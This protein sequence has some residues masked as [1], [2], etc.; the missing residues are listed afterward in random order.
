MYDKIHYNKKKKTKT[1]KHHIG[2]S[3]TFKPGVCLTLHGHLNN[4]GG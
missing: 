4:V 2:S 3:F 1:N